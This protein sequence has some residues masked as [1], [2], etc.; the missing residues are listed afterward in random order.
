LAL[1]GGAVE[2]LDPDALFAGASAEQAL[3]DA[4]QKA[5]AT[6]AFAVVA[7]SRSARSITL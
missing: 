3:S 5:A 4:A 2:R 1:P 7:G 6:T